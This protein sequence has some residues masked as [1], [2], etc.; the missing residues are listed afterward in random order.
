MIYV[1]ES[2]RRK[3]GRRTRFVTVDEWFALSLA[4]NVSPLALLFGDQMNEQVDVTPDVSV[5]AERALSWLLGVGNELS[6]ADPENLDLAKFQAFT[7][8]F[9]GWATSVVAAAGSAVTSEGN[10]QALFEGALSQ[11]EETLLAQAKEAAEVAVRAAL[12]EI[13]ESRTDGSTTD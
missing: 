8:T 12:A 10:V 7:A 1:I 11:R 6:G 13:K 4:L 5:P 3:A 9:P 2:G